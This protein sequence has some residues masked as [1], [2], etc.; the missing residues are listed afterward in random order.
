MRFEK[1]L[2]GEYRAQRDDSLGVTYIWVFRGS[3]RK[4]YWTTGGY[5]GYNE[6]LPGCRGPFSSRKAAIADVIAYFQYNGIT[7]WV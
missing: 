2:P 7:H 4:W 1:I 3:G 5:P 6:W